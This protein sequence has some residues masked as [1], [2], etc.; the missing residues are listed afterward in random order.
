MNSIEPSKPPPERFRKRYVVAPAFV[1]L[2]CCCAWGAA[3][4][5]RLGSE[6]SA[7]RASLMGSVGGRWNKKIAIHAGGLTMG[8][9]RAGS[10]LFHLPPEPRA[11][12]EALHGAEVGVYKLQ[13]APLSVD[14]AA[15]L[16][17]ADKAMARRGWDRMV[18]VA[19]ENELVAVYV[20]RKGISPGRM[21]A[22]VMV[23]H[24]R[25]LVVVS[26]RGN[27]KPLLEIANKR[28]EVSGKRQFFA[29]SF[30]AGNREG[31]RLEGR[32]RGQN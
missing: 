23:L 7:L 20:P 8:L 19:K 21:R 2:L 3:G 24:D 6:T 5:F 28:F 32:G 18:G 16:S 17:A 9:V 29:Q 31:G 15:I 27:L 13:Q 11:A 22:C 12:I 10:R 14:H 30:V 26:A 25:D 4:Y 1:F